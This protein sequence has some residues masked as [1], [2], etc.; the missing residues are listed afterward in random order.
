VITQTEE[1]GA[2]EEHLPENG[3][4]AIVYGLNEEEAA[5]IAEMTDE[6]ARRQAEEVRERSIRH[7]LHTQ[8]DM[9][10]VPI[11]E[12][13]DANITG[14]EVLSDNEDLSNTGGVV[15]IGPGMTVEDSGSEHSEQPEAP[16]EPGFSLVVRHVGLVNM[17][18]SVVP[19]AWSSTWIQTRAEAEQRR[20]NEERFKWMRDADLQMLTIGLGPVPWEH[21]VDAIS[22]TGEY[23]F[24]AIEQRTCSEQVLQTGE[25]P[26]PDSLVGAVLVVRSHT[27]ITALK[28]VSYGWN[29]PGATA[30][31]MSL[32]AESLPVGAQLDLI[33]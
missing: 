4:Q 32:M 17:P 2:D 13:E 25:P 21:F 20:A 15:M 10:S 31:M 26:G 28:M 23:Q 27:V 33:V 29:A 1:F 18:E 24:Q 3:V 12:D 16:Q 6:I 5:E 14:G 11:T 7:F 9:S 30:K 19:S 8:C 22:Q